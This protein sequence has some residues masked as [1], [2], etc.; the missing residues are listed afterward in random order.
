MNRRDP[1]SNPVSNEPEPTRAGKLARGAIVALGFVSAVGITGLA[2]AD[3]NRVEG[4]IDALRAAV[5]AGAEVSHPVLKS[6]TPTQ[7]RI[8]PICHSNSYS[9]S[10]GH[11][12]GHGQTYEC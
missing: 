3:V 11:N 6:L 9:Q 7:E 12:Q 8:R 1:Q 4:N 2:E 5:G 10:A